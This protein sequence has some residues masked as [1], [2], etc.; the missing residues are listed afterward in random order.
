MFITNFEDVSVGKMANELE[1]ARSTITRSLNPSSDSIENRNQELLDELEK[2]NT[3]QEV[4]E[5]FELTKI[6]YA[7]TTARQATLI[8][9]EKLCFIALEQT[10]G[11]EEILELFKKMPGGNQT[12]DLSLV[13]QA[14]IRKLVPFFMEKETEV[15]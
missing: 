10:S 15:S 4:I 1:V 6:Q 14:G 12:P 9:W 11:K 7:N 5:V 2:T 13:Q 3:I 8:K